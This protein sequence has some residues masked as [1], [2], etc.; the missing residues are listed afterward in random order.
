MRPRIDLLYGG[1]GTSPLTGFPQAE[2]V[3]VLGPQYQSKTWRLTPTFITLTAH[4]HLPSEAGVPRLAL[5]HAG[6][7]PRHLVLR[8]PERARQAVDHRR[9]A[10]GDGRVLHEER[11]LLRVQQAR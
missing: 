10:A 3:A 7:A 9:L 4:D 8:A 5:E 1:A 11:L 6:L 2:S